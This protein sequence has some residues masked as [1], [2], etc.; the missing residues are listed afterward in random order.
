MRIESIQGREIFDSRCHPTVETE[1]LRFADQLGDS[2]RN[3]GRQ[4]SRDLRGGE[5]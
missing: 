2:A 1:V 3:P 4:A 5:V